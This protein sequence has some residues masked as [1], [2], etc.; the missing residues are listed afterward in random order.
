MQ[1][2]IDAASLDTKLAKRDQHLRSADF[3]DVEYHP[4]VTFTSDTARLDGD[5]LKVRGD[6]RAAG[7]QIPLTVDATLR[8]VDGELEVEAT[9][10]ADHRQLGML[11]SRALL[12]LERDAAL[13][14]EYGV[15][16]STATRAIDGDTYR[17]VPFRSPSPSPTCHRHGCSTPAA[18]RLFRAGSWSYDAVSKG[19]WDRAGVVAAV[20]AMGQFQR[21]A[22]SGLRTLGAV[23][24]HTAAG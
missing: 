4:E 19:A 15:G 17:D 8:A 5:T 21:R 18:V 12:R 7:R 10:H 9:T 2:A 20:G 6:L 16:Q 24:V 23:L 13:T 14:A 22:G 11:W 3:F 1:L